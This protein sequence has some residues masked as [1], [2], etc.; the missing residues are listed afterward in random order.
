VDV[1]VLDAVLPGAQGNALVREMKKSSESVRII[2]TSGVFN[3]ERVQ[4]LIES[5]ADIFLRKPYTL[6]TLSVSLHDVLS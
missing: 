4:S 6:R 2:I 5:G 3:R 1:V